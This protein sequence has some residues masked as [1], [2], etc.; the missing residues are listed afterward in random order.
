MRPSRWSALATY[1]LALLATAY[2]L[3]PFAWLVAASFSTES[4]LSLGRLVPTRP[5]ADAYAAFLPAAAAPAPED[6]RDGAFLGQ[7]NARGFVPALMT[8]VL[9]ALCVTLVNL[10]FGSLAA[11]A[12]ARIPTRATLPL[13]LFYLV[14]RSIPAVAL[15]I[16]MYLLIKNA[17][18]LDQPLS[19]ILAHSTFTLPFTI[20]LLKGYFQTVPLDLERAARVD[21]CSRLKSLLRVFLPVTAPGLVAAG[22]FSFI[23]SWGEFLYAFLFTTRHAR[24][25]T[26][27]VSDFVS[28]IDIPFPLIAA[29]GVLAVLLPVVLAFLF[30]RYIVRGLGGAV[31]G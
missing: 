9:I 7:E 26:V 20:W 17:G 12:L 23:F 30:Q 2:L 27:L 21:G 19:V 22:I 16:P 10:C 31:T 6:A 1:L 13:L 18:L 3:A 11:Y 28:E 29:G 4:E 25:V 8:S 14:S 24:T 15:M 5:T